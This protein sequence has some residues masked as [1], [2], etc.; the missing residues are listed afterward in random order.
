MNIGLIDSSINSNSLDIPLNVMIACNDLMTFG[1]QSLTAN[2]RRIFIETIYN[3]ITREY[4]LSKF[5]SFSAVADSLS[6]WSDLI[7]SVSS[8]N[9]LLAGMN[10]EEALNYLFGNNNGSEFLALR[11]L[12]NDD[13]VFINKLGI[14]DW[15]I[16]NSKCGV[17]VMDA[18]WTYG[19]AG[20]W[21][22][23]KVYPSHKKGVIIKRRTNTSRTCRLYVDG[24]SVYNTTDGATVYLFTEFSD[25]TT[26]YAQTGSGNNYD[27]RWSHLVWYLPLV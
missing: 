6:C 11:N 20:G 3:K 7:N 5:S 18:T 1:D 22:S 14:T 27:E 8:Q 10:K 23:M 4:L 13:D 2:E 24:T 21:N 9:L 16:T 12:I 25:N 15:V 17:T 19:T 26:T